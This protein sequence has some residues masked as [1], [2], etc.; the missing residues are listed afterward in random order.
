[1]GKIRKFK[2]KRTDNQE[3]K[4]QTDSQETMDVKES[5]RNARNNVK[6]SV[7]RAVGVILLGV[8][9]SIYVQVLPLVFVFL[10]GYMRLPLKGSA[11]IMDL[12]IW[13]LTCVGILIPSIYAFITWMKF[14]WKRF[15]RNPQSFTLFSKKA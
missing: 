4:N 7:L 15:V 5:E 3:V 6:K 1:M 14:V 9:T 8:S 13:I 10:G 12:S 11:T 2:T